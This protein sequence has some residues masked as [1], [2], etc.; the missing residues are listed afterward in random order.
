M[1]QNEVSTKYMKRL[2]RE[3]SK[4]G[5]ELKEMESHDLNASF[6]DNSETER[7]K[8]SIRK[9]TGFNETSP[10]NYKKRNKYLPGDH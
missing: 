5:Q 8:T 2:Q 4:V 6:S 3:M 9:A 1:S 10:K 7:E